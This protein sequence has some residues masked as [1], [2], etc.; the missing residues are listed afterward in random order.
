MNKKRKEIIMNSEISE[1]KEVNLGGYPQKILIDGQK[2]TN[3]AVI[4]LHG[5]PGSPIP[6]SVGCRGLFPEITEK[7][8][9]V[10]WDQLGC[11][12]NNRPIDDSFK[13][14]D[15]VLM[16]EDLIREVRGLL[17]SVRLYLFG[18]S[19]GS[20]LTALAAAR[21]KAEIDGA[22][23]YGQVLC[24]MTFND[25][26]YEALE[27][28]KMPDRERKKLSEMKKSRTLRNAKQIMAYIRK[29]TE[30][31]VCK[32]GKKASLYGI[33]KGLLDSPDYRLKDF[34]AVMIN[35]YMKNSS[36]INELLDIDL[37]G[38]LSDIKIPYKIIQGDTDIVT[39]TKEIEKYVSQSENGNIEFIGL[40]NSGHMPGEEAMERII[41]EIIKMSEY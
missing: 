32:S 30:G 9:L 7:L 37:R 22:A 34:S 27:R 40:K 21:G 23:V 4:C 13:I 2:K 26:V 17:P 24:N 16:T 10:C 38:V 1:V 39:S 6:F 5:G 19:W 41:G 8:T 31:Y 28:S 29:Y 11:G 15:F 35:G 33:I 36:L 20:V 18:V 25:E 14:S 12:I 3:P